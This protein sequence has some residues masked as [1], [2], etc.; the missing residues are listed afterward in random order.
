MPRNTCY[1]SSRYLAEVFP[2]LRV[3]YGRLTFVVRG[4]PGGVDHA[5]NLLPDG[6]ILDSTS[7]LGPE[8]EDIQYWESR[9][10]LPAS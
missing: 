8:A 9:S 7:T 1:L 6:R 10:S 3:C 2:E 4:I 5:W